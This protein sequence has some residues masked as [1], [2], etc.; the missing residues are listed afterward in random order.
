MES[1]MCWRHP[2]LNTWNILV[3]FCHIHFPLV[4]MIGFIEL[5]P[6]HVAG[7]YLMRFYEVMIKVS[8][9]RSWMMHKSAAIVGKSCS[10]LVRS[11]RGREVV[12][13]GWLMGKHLKNLNVGLSEL[14]VVHVCSVPK[15]NSNFAM[16]LVR[17]VNSNWMHLMWW[18]DCII[19]PSISCLNHD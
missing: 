3:F 16:M 10:L 15:P 11:A 1:L 9:F 19:S 4:A 7:S 2:G 17:T 12:V 18:C 14:L 13:D 8:C 5:E 6:T